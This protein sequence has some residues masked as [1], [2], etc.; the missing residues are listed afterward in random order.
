MKKILLYTLGLA[1]ILSMNSCAEDFLD[2]NN[3]HQLS[4]EKQFDSDDAVAAATAPLY[5]Y[6]WYGF[7]DK[8][9]YGMGDG[10]ANNITAQY[11]EYIYPYTNFTESSVSAGLSDAWSSLYTVVAQ[12]N[13]TINNIQ[14]YSTGSVSQSAKTKAIAEA[15]FMRGT[16][17]W[18][19]ASLWGCGIIYEN[20]A[21]LVTNY[22]VP[23]QPRLDVMEFAIRDLEYAAK[24]LPTTQG[25][26]GRVTKYS[27]FGMLSRM[28][29]S[30]AGLTTEGAYDGTNA[31][32]DFDRGTR[33][34][35]YLEL[36]RK[37]ARKVIRESGA[38]LLDNYFDLFYYKTI[39]NNEESLFQLQFLQGEGIGGAAQSMPRFFG[40]STTVNDGNN[41]GAATYCSYDLWME[42]KDY[43]DATLGTKHVDDKIRRHNSVASYGEEYPELS[44]DEN[45]Y[46]YGITEE[47]STQGAN[48][49]KYVIGS[50][51]ING[52]SAIHS[53]GINSYMLRLAE[54]YLN[55]AEAIM[56][57]NESTRD[58]EALTYFNKVR[59]RAGMPTK[60]KIT[61]EDLRHEFRVELAFEGL[62]W[63]QLLRRSYYRQQEV[64]SYVNNQYRNASYWEASTK[65]YKLSDTYTKPGPQVSTATASNL[66]LPMSNIDQNKNPY[67][68]S[69]ANGNVPT[70]PYQFGEREVD[71]AT[72][73]D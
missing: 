72:L 41:W 13:N 2:Q 26:K 23:A 18:Y 28:Y 47:A 20:T 63:Y 27:A 48:V 58:E 46:I 21:N 64:I 22:V 31:A 65:T 38:K 59:Q 50:N 17:Y 25:D 3:S 56:G 52:I 37:A 55:Y 36:A 69:D 11:S 9:S 70:T 40:W 14:S 10:R 32:T 4:P 54:V 61:Y 8:F 5:S 68:K 7:N 24:Y 15:R 33:N 66:V 67:L 34:P 1:G 29:L 12:S 30:M 49:K 60:D 53:A 43:E 42:F 73:F 51:K 19:I 6:V 39:N 44:T 45:P 71:E 35:Y 16:A 62:Y 57:N